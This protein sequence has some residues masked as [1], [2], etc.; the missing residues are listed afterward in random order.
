MVPRNAAAAE[1]AFGQNLCPPCADLYF[2]GKEW[3]SLDAHRG[4]QTHPDY[5]DFMSRSFEIFDREGFS[6]QQFYLVPNDPVTTRGSPFNA[7]VTEV[8]WIYYPESVN[9]EATQAKYDTYR[10]KAAQLT[11]VQGA[12]GGWVLEEAEAGGERA[13][14]FIEFTGQASTAEH[15]DAAKKLGKE[16]GAAI[17]LL[18]GSLAKTTVHV[19][20]KW[21]SSSQWQ[22][23]QASRH[24]PVD[25]KPKYEDIVCMH[26]ETGH[27]QIKTH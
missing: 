25:K 2:R 22:I 14:L 21:Q 6:V 9:K 7:P 5:P 12:Q 1:A 11:A 16:S 27:C 3:E 10:A 19:A 24:E 18:E 20:F 26:R 13:K 15:T 8:S 17:A 4:W 23:S